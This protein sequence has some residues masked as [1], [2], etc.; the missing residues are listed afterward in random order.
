M[1][2]RKI[3]QDLGLT[4][5]EAAE[6]MKVTLRTFQRWENGEVE[7]SSYVLDRIE[8]KLKTAVD[9]KNIVIKRVM[10]YIPC[11]GPEN[12]FEDV[13]YNRKK[14]IGFNNKKGIIYYNAPLVSPKIEGNDGE[15]YDFWTDFKEPG[16]VSLEEAI[17]LKTIPSRLVNEYASKVRYNSI[18]ND[19]DRKIWKE[20]QEEARKDPEK[21]FPGQ[22]FDKELKSE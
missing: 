10:T 1:D 20:L 16:Y 6:I 17:N 12:G 9:R 14:I 13:E 19:P 4:Q 15:L 5:T 21:F 7:P 11:G 22:G 8:D 3:R 18:K 2:I